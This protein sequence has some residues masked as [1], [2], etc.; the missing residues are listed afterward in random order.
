M[1]TPWPRAF[2]FYFAFL[3]RGLLLFF[4]LMIPYYLLYGFI[5]LVGTT[6]AD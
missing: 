1:E 5:L 6:P 4:V 3:W 2:V